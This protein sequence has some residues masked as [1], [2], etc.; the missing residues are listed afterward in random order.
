M[1]K[2]CEMK[3]RTMDSPLGKIEISGCEQGLHGINLHGRKI[4]DTDPVEAPAPPERLGGPEEVTE[5]LAQ[6]AAW[7]GAYFHEPAVLE[8]RPVPA[9]HHP[10]FQKDSFTRQALWKLLKAV[11][12]GETISYQQL[13]ALAGNPKAARAV[14]EAMRSNPE[15]RRGAAQ[16]LPTCLHSDGDW[17]RPCAAGPPAG[18]WEAHF[19]PAG[20][21]GEAQPP[22]T[23]QGALGVCAPS[24]TPEPVV[25]SSCVPNTHLW[26]PRDFSHKPEDSRSHSGSGVQSELRAQPCSPAGGF[27]TV[28]RPS[29]SCQAKNHTYLKTAFSLRCRTTRLRTAT[30]S[31][32]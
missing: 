20:D 11:K 6:C 2:T 19:L 10:I 8:E 31:G 3:Y 4:P 15:G 17:R 32:T 25:S 1:N 21:L 14:G 18:P 13:A 27:H 9:L 12:F 29:A 28:S 22:A 16:S 30:P 5:P 26:P 23:P 24:L 7:L